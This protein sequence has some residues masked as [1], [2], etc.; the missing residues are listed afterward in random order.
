MIYQTGRLN[1]GKRHILQPIAGG[2]HNSLCEL[3]VND[4]NHVKPLERTERR[5]ICK[6]CLTRADRARRAGVMIPQ[7]MEGK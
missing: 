4:W 3:G 5:F 6:K 2:G 1:T 7:P